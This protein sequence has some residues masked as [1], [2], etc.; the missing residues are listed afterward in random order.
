MDCSPLH[1]FRHPLAVDGIPE[2]VEHSREN[3]LADRSLQRPASVFHHD[4][5]SETLGRSQRDSTYVVRI[6]LS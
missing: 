5:A 3:S 1:I 2:N 4:T 6:E